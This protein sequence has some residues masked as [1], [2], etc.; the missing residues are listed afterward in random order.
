RLQRPADECRESAGSRLQVPEPLEV[1]EPLLQRLADAVHHG[2][3]GLQSLLVGNLHD[4]KPT[5]RAR[6]LFRHL[7]ADPLHENL[8]AAS[9]NR[10]ETG[11]HQLAN[12]LPSIHA[13][14][15]APEIHFAGTEPVDV[16]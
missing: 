4:F 3:T 5:V 6:L 2:A 7:V 10:I 14:E 13:V 8:A 1:L 16:D 12:D 11:P 9:G 15:R